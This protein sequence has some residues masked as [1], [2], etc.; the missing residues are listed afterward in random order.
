[1]TGFSETL[2]GR[3]GYTG[4]AFTHA[5]DRFR[6]APP[7]ALLRILKQLAL[8]EHPKLVVD[9]GAGTGLS[10]R[11]WTDDA[12][13]IIGIEPNEAMLTEARKATRAGNIEYLSRFAS[14]TGLPDGAADIV[15][16]AQAFHWMQPQPVL[17]EAARVLRAGGVFAAYDYDVPP[18]VHPEL[19]AAFAA[20]F[21]AR[22]RARTRLGLEAGASTWP[23]EQHLKQIRSSGYFRYVRE[24]VCHSCGET[25]AD[26]LIGLAESIG[27]PQAIFG[28]AAP[29]VTQT[30]K[31]L[32]TLARR[33]LQRPHPIVHCY[34]IRTG[35]K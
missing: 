24:A 12:E 13:Q 3:S 10:T 35:S 14:E 7:P 5:Y 11:A 16:C 29:E 1:L 28:D 8:A 15:T 9:L 23:K 26:R 19:D 2:I 34:R 20:H 4:E 30:F 25:D 21:D 6:P 22:R 32:R 31:Q 18:I 17:Q 33:T 27:G